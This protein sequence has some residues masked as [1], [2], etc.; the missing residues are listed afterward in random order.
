MAYK[1]MS[2]ICI[3]RADSAGAA[4]ALES[5]LAHFP[6]APDRDRVVQILKKLGR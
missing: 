1:Y 4:R 5:Y 2:S 6:D 3:K